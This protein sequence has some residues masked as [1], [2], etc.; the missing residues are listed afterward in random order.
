MDLGEEFALSEC[1]S[2]TCVLRA[3]IGASGSG[4]GGTGGSPNVGGSGGTDAPPEC[5]TH[6]EC[7]DKAEGRQAMC[8]AGRCV[9]LTNNFDEAVGGKG[10]CYV[11]A[12]GN[13]GTN[14]DS[15]LNGN[16]PLFVFGALS[17]VEPT[18]PNTSNY[19]LNYRFAV[20]EFVSKG[21]VTLGG[22]EHAPL[23]LI[24]NMITTDEELSRNIDFLVDTVGVPG[25]IAPL[26]AKKLKDQFNRVHGVKKK[27]VLFLSPIESDATVTTVADDKLMWHLLADAS[28]VAKPYVPLVSRAESYWRGELGLAET[29]K[30]KVALVVSDAPYLTDIG[31]FISRSVK[32]NGAIA[33]TQDATVYKRWDVPSWTDSQTEL[34]TQLGEILSFRPHIIISAAGTEFTNLL[35]AQIEK[36]WLATTHRPFYV[37]SP[38]NVGSAAF[39]GV[40][41]Q[42][43][44]PAGLQSRVVGVNVAVADDISLYRAYYDALRGSVPT[45][46]E[47][48]DNFYDAVYWM[49]YAAHA[50]GV[51]DTNITGQDLVVGMERLVDATAA[52]QM[53]IGTSGLANHLSYLSS[54]PDSRASFIDTLGAPNFLPSGARKGKGSVWCIE[55]DD[56]TLDYAYDVLQYRP[57]NGGEL[58]LPQGSTGFPCFSGFWT[59]P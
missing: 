4:G 19:T 46:E 8:K 34:T 56:G 11:M 49:L 24:C 42:G 18:Q 33:N 13:L 12:D 6:T 31:N 20:K 17:V 16:L 44:V 57:D 43:G 14:A 23:G 29:V 10:S 53:T 45:A 9:P 35:F 40:F 15:V 25:I 59:D 22:V 38:H 58:Y 41:T 39:K 52:Y 7:I 48:Y 47:G 51:T 1:V 28:E 50:G 27:D 2:N 55:N 3:D 26:P 54:N 32:F 30:T 37:M 36:S 5:T 21:N